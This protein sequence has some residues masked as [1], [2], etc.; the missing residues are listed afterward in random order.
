MR[1][2]SVGQQVGLETQTV[3]V[4]Q[5]HLGLVWTSRWELQGDRSW[6]TEEKAF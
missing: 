4:T 6:A 1:G 3:R 5:G 2:G